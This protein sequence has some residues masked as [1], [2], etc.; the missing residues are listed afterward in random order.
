ME[1]TGRDWIAIRGVIDGKDVDGK[2]AVRRR[3]R[4][5]T[6]LPLSMR[7]TAIASPCSCV[8]SPPRDVRASFPP[9]RPAPAWTPDHRGRAWR[10]YLIAAALTAV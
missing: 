1:Q 3:A 7:R 6:P 4:R 5:M 9:Y 2:E 10:R 8:F